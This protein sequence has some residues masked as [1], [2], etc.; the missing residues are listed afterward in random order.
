LVIIR[1]MFYGLSPL[2]NEYKH[3]P[4]TA[5][6]GQPYEDTMPNYYLKKVY[7]ELELLEVKK[8]RATKL[9]GKMAQAGL[10]TIAETA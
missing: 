3:N 8:E 9:T 1:I 4:T 6:K 10:R 7:N 2:K 5:A